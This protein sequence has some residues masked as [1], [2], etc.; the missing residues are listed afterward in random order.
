MAKISFDILSWGETSCRKLS[1]LFSTKT[2]YLPRSDH[3]IYFVNAGKITQ[4]FLEQKL[5]K[6]ASRPSEE[7][8]LPFIKIAYFL[9]YNRGSEDPDSLR[10]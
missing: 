10:K 8:R 9:L 2:S 6:E 1:H 3:A 7:E 4:Q 5:T